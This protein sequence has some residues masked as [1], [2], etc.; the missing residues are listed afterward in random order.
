MEYF[1]A[2]AAAG[3]FATAAVSCHVSPSAIAAAID[4]L[5]RSLEVQLFIRRKAKG[6]VLTALG[7]RLLTEARVLLGHGAVFASAVKQDGRGVSGRFPIGVYPTLSPFL[8]PGLLEHFDQN[9][10]DVELD[11]V[12]ASSPQL[13]DAVL[14]GRIEG[15]LL[16]N[17]AGMQDLDFQEVRRLRP[18]ALLSAQ[19][20]LAG[21]SEISLRELADERLITLNVTPSNENINTILGA[22]GVRP[23]E[24]VG[25]DNYELVRCLVARNFGF[26]V[27]LQS[28]Q[29]STTYDGNRVVAVRIADDVPSTRVGLA[30]ASG[31]RLTG[32]MNAL[33]NFL[34]AA[35]FYSDESIDNHSSPLRSL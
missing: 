33:L 22:A 6:M 31:A 10:P 18:I 8:V 25:Y 12:E 32:R 29:S 27:M 30:Y 11:I 28:P 3:S 15:A 21:R 23:K 20:H 17:V 26:S 13:R 7:A 16:Y 35:N 14:Q 9:Y 1:E 34:T 19:H 2:V 24:R 5:E 4:E